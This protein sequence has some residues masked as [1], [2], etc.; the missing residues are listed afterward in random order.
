MPAGQAATVL[1]LGRAELAAAVAPTSTLKSIMPDP[2][3]TPPVPAR[4]K[5]LG[6]QEQSLGGTHLQR[7]TMWRGWPCGALFTTGANT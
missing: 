6:G 5:I 3:Q 7:S 2:A 1:P 4:Q